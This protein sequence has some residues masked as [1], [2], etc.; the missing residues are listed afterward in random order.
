[1]PGPHSG[2]FVARVVLPAALPSLF[3]LTLAAMLWHASP[4]DFVPVWSDEV[5]YWNETAAFMR[6]GFRAGYITVGEDPAP[7]AFSRFG[8]HGVGYA[9]LYGSL[10]RLAGWRPYSQYLVHLLVIPLCA[11]TWFWARR[12]QPSRVADALL[13]A[14]FWPLLVYLPTGMTEPLH[15]G[16][17]FL[18]AALL[19]R[20][21]PSR[22]NVLMRTVLLGVAAFLRPTWAVILPAL[23]WRS[24]PRRLRW[25]VV[26]P[27]A[28]LFFLASFLLQ[29]WTS[30]PYPHLAWRPAAFAEPAQAIG[31][32][33]GRIAANVRAF[34]TP[35]EDW[36][37]TLYRIELSAGLITAFILWR[38]QGAGHPWRVE[39]AAWLVLPVFAV[40]LAAAD[41]PSGRELRVLTPHALAALLVVA[42]A[43]WAAVPAVL[44]LIVLPTLLLTY[45]DLHDGHFTRGA[46]AWEFAHA[47]RGAL[48]FDDKATSGWENTILMHA[49][50]LAPGMLGIPPGIGISFVLDWTDQASPPRSRYVLLREREERVFPTTGLVRLADVPAGTIYVREA[51][52]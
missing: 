36:F 8:P 25:P 5:V 22:S 43:R 20:Q 7:A 49:D 15:F 27:A 2:T 34:V 13:V 37:V 44:N 14:T 10:A 9:M 23:F 21:A 33:L 48:V 41:V 19:E 39:T 40:Q 29:T 26:I 32:L 46:E 42:G 12:H 35:H 52:R 50:A 17:A 47:V 18:F 45:I 16:L 31:P 24:A 11:G 30:A 3:T 1:M 28:G 51:A 4:R 6:G 38:R